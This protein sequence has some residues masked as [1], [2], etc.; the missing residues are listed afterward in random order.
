MG[1]ASTAEIAIG[2]PWPATLS[3]L[4]VL[5]A[6]LLVQ[7]ILV[8]YAGL[9]RI[10]LQ[11]AATAPSPCSWLSAAKGRALVA[12]NAQRSRTFRPLQ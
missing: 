7:A 9:R 1:F 12:R 8:A 10:F 6:G 3:A 5:R 11:I 2:L 4:K